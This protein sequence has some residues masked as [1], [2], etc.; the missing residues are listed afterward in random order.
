MRMHHAVA[1][2]PPLLPEELAALARIETLHDQLRL[3]VAV[4]RAWTGTLRRTQSARNA[5]GSNAIEGHRVSIEDAA[6]A[7]DGAEMETRNKDDERA[8]RNY[9]RAMSY[10]LLLTDDAQAEL[11]SQLVRSLHFML[12]EGSPKRP[13]RWRLGAVTVTD[14]DGATVYTGPD[15]ERLPGLVDATMHAMAEDARAG[16][17]LLVRAAMA[18]FR[19]VTVHPF[20]DGNGRMSRILQTTTLALGGMAATELCSV[21]EYL[22]REGNTQ[23]YYDVLARAGGPTYDPSLDARPWVRYML[24]AHYEQAQLV[25]RRVDEAGE[26]WLRLHELRR[27][28]GLLERTEAALGIAAGGLSVTNASYRAAVGADTGAS[29][30]P[31]TASRDLKALADSGLLDQV[32]AAGGAHYVAAG[33]LAAARSEVRGTRRPVDSTG[34]FELA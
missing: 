3:S 10:A 2:T 26:L 28:A 30:K 17:P 7:A 9:Q 1:E 13:G 27:A 4:R 12:M 18:H 11:N 31:V 32:G 24:R 23:A 20:A 25:Q 6:A 22:G 14:Q 16:V 29:L 15:P 8:L 19:L 21:E 34:L 5:R 33:D